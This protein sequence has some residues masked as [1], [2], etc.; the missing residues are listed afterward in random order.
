MKDIAGAFFKCVYL[1]FNSNFFMNIKNPVSKIRILISFSL[2][3]SLAGC[4]I[5]KEK[6]KPVEMAL[7]V[8][9]KNIKLE[10]QPETLSYSGTIDA[11][12]TV[13][14]GFSVSG[15]VNLANVK[16]GQ[17]VHTG[18]LLATVEAVEYQNAV[19]LAQA[20]LDQAE[21]NFKRLNELHEKGS[22]PE[23]DFIT[24]KI[25][26]KAELTKAQH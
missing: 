9:T 4:D 22:L 3:L 17:H 19:L 1:S 8:I 26:L 5:N 24:A 13:S 6:T 25:S 12:N 2:L 23:R 20:G 14:L 10:G 15:R 18:E 11:D 7:K 21:D 16:E